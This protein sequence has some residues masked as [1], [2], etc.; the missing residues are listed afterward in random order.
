MPRAPT[1]CPQRRRRINQENPLRALVV[2][3]KKNGHTSPKLLQVVVTYA[4]D[5]AIDAGGYSRLH[6]KKL[7]ERKVKERRACEE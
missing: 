1:A 2:K 6:H 3:A 7:C 4:R 5:S